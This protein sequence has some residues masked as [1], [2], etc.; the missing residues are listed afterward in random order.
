MSVCRQAQE[1]ANTL[2]DART[3]S[4]LP[5][6]EGAVKG[7]REGNGAEEKGEGGKEKAEGGRGRAEGGKEYRLMNDE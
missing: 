5:G 6:G 4:I 7:V 1:A 2:F 3:R